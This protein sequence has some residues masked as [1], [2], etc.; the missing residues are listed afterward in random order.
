MI[1]THLGF[2]GNIYFRDPLPINT[3]SIGLLCGREDEVHHFITETFS[4]NKCLKIIT[5]EVGVGKTSFVNTCQQIC[6]EPGHELFKDYITQSILPS[7]K[8]IEVTNN[9][10]FDSFAIKAVISLAVNIKSHYINSGQKMPEKLN[11]YVDY[12]TNVRLQV[13]PGG[14]SIAASV[15]G[16]GGQIGMDGGSYAYQEI[17][18]PHNSFEQLLKL[19]LNYK[20]IRGVFMLIDNIDMVKESELI[21]VLN[22]IRDSYFSIAHVYWILVGQRGLSEIIS[23]KSRRLG[24]YITGTE[25]HLDKLQPRVFLKA[26]EERQAAFIIRDRKK[27]KE[28]KDLRRKRALQNVLNKPDIKELPNIKYLDKYADFKI[29]SPV[30]ESTHLMIYDFTHRELRESFKVCYDI[31]L[32]AQEYIKSHGQLPLRLAM[33]YMIEYCDSMTSFMDLKGND[34]G[35]LQKIYLMDGVTN[36]KYEDFNYKSAS[37]FDSLLRNFESKGLL[38]KKERGGVKFYDISW[39]L[40]ALA[41]CGVIGKECLN[42][43]FI[44]HFPDLE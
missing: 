10:S 31:C 22:E 16:T 30:D 33:N 2:Q 42:K 11:E 6:Y 17:K 21:R 35:I 23:S 28:F 8:K 1:W 38:I 32:R 34:I 27:L 15:L 41:V 39:R 25:L 37:G 43:S 18:S 7:F 14:F 29:F 13:H 24:G 5:G 40:E 44:N 20:S 19:L 26:I 36:R 9:D 4:D 12:W 3:F